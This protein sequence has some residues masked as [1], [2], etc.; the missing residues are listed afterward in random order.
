MMYFPIRVIALGYRL[1][2]SEFSFLI[3][4]ANNIKLKEFGRNICEKILIY[5]HQNAQQD[6]LKFV[7]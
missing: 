2:A 4:K 7:E 5:L 6:K 3:N 1:E